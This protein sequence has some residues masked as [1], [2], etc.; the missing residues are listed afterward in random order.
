MRRRSSCSTDGARGRP[1]MSTSPESGGSSR[2]IIFSSVVLPEPD[3]P[4]M[5]RNSCGQTSEIDVANRDAASVGPADGAQLDARL[6]ARLG[7][8]RPSVV[9][10]AHS[11]VTLPS[12]VLR[13]ESLAMS[14]PIWTVLIVAKQT[15]AATRP[16]RSRCPE[17]V[18]IRQDI[19]R[20]VQGTRRN[21][22]FP[23]TPREV[24]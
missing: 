13:N 12:S 5:T 21:Y 19:G 15:C 6:P 4:R 16:R 24:W 23:S 7:P 14:S 17:D 1:S 2:L 18:S 3:S 20:G 11:H 10:H 9:R 8:M 22:H